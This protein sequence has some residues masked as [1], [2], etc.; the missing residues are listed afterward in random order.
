MM[1]KVFKKTLG[2]LCLIA[3]TS[4][5][6]ANEFDLFQQSAIWATGNYT[7]GSNNGESYGDV[8]QTQVNPISNLGDGGR[9]HVFVDNDAKFNYG[10]G[11]SYHIA[12][13]QTRFFVNYDH[14]VDGDSSSDDY[15]R[16]I[17]VDPATV[18]PPTRT[19]GSGYVS[20]RT[21]ELR[22]GLIQT[23]K[24]MPCFDLDI[25]GFVEWDRLKRKMD[26]YV[27]QAGITGPSS[28][29][30]EDRV[31]GWGLGIGS[32]A[33][34]RP[35]RCYPSI[36]FFMEGNTALIW[37]A[38]EFEEQAF[39]AQQTSPG[40]LLYS[41]DPEKTRSMVGKI[42]I[43][44]GVNYNRHFAQWCD[45]ALDVT[46]GL[47]YLNVFN[48]F[49]NGNTYSNPLYYSTQNPAAVNYAANLGYP[50]DWGRIGPF[51]T[52]AIGGVDA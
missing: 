5:V 26:Q 41:Y 30:I 31:Q 17:D 15:I 19:D 20:H 10:L 50:N 33:R 23:L 14:F 3:L 8:L 25:A 34:T 45:V 32:R 27:S 37:G 36:A 6:W 16:N 52:F 24:F 42:D 2:S 12:N 51:L 39:D 48:A 18:V 47:K 44:L 1:K 38:N 4:A 7:Q 46:L 11:Y 49:K 9:R 28:L 22:L 43:S 29:H 40:N 35:F 21:D 13:S